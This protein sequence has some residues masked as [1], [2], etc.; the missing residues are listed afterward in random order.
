M[1]ALLV[2]RT[3]TSRMTTIVPLLIF[4]IT[5]AFIF[6]CSY[7]R[8]TYVNKCNILSLYWS[9]YRYIMLFFVFCYSLCLKAYFVWQEFCYSIF[10][11]F[12]FAWN[13]F[14]HTLSFRLCV[15]LVRKWASRRQHLNGS[16][17]F[18]FFCIQSVT[19]YLLTGPMWKEMKT[20][21]WKCCIN[22][23]VYA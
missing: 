2:R 13:T 11:L 14:F 20:C 9:V 3:M 19:L 5:F 18:F 23:R 22:C 17:F 12:S 16:F 7:L 8:Y 15:F 6:R 4:L 1:G 10:L 21:L